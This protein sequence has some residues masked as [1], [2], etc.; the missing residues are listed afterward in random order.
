ML[1]TSSSFIVFLPIVFSLYYL[2][3]IRH[4]WLILLASSYIFYSFSGIQYVAILLYVTICAF[5][6]AR[7]LSA[8]KKAVYIVWAIVL[9]ITPLIFFKYSGFIISNLNIIKKSMG[10]AQ[11]LSTM[12]LALPI[13]ISFYTF[14]ALGYV[15]DVYKKKYEP[16]E[17]IFH[18]AAGISFFPCLVS[19]PI[20]R[21]NKLVPQII[22][23]ND[24]DYSKATNGIKLIAWG[25]FEKLVIADNLAV[26]VDRVFSDVTSFEGLS[27]LV[28]SLFFSIQIYC[29]FSGYSDIAV[30]IGKLF[31]VELTKNFKSP[32]LSLSIQEFW[33]RW[34]ISLSS[35]FRDYV[36]I[37]LGG[38]RKGSLRKNINVFITMIVSGLWHGA[39]WTFVV[40]GGLHGIVQIIENIIGNR[41]KRTSRLLY[42]AINVVIVF[43][44]SSFL[45]I[46]FRAGSFSDAWYV[47]SHMFM[48]VLDLHTYIS[49]LAS[50]GI[51][52]MELMLIAIEIIVLFFYDF[53]SLKIDVIKEIS[54]RPMIVRWSIYC[55]F[56][57]A[58]I[59]LAYKGG[60]VNF[61]YAGF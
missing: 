52:K 36:Y 9:T 13:G 42:K 31:G 3:P 2:C 33:R 49:G 58:I 32:Y 51:H 18:L 10:S 48:G 34:H 23:G 40:W 4:R 50:I 14:S 55:L 17:N 47:I 44:I 27:L 59:Q 22:K 7:L 37:L 39:A 6:F 30:G 12:E 8:N 21:Q 28:G 24:F 43:S 53:Y 15:I 29:D 19:G 16:F 26:Y 20:E 46:F 61:V 45:W 57:I 25:L 56:T 35:W 54:A 11:Y 1:F 41:D 60:A 5:F 38:N